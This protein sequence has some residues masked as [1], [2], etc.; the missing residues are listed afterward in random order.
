MVLENHDHRHRP[1]SWVIIVFH[2]YPNKYLISYKFRNQDENLDVSFGT[3]VNIEL[4]VDG[5][6]GLQKSTPFS[7]H[8]QCKTY[9]VCLYLCE[10]FIFLCALHALPV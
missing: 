9:T 5:G 10:E 4:S 1:A 7:V 6:G 8:Y 3:G 2:S